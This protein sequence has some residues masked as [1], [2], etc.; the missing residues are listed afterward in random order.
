VKVDDALLAGDVGMD[1]DAD[2]VAGTEGWGPGWAL[3][4]GRAFYSVTGRTDRPPQ[5]MYPTSEA[6]FDE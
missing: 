4:P 6:T 1:K 5:R 2:D 3:S